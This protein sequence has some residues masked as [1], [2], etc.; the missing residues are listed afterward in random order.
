M[1]LLPLRLF[2]TLLFIAFSILGFSAYAQSNTAQEKTFTTITYKTSQKGEP[3]KLDIFQPDKIIAGQ[4]NPVVMIIHGGGWVEGDRTLK[5]IYYMQ[6]LQQSLTERG[7]AV[8]SIDYTLVGKDVHFMAPIIDCKDAIRWVKANADKYHFDADHIGLWGGSAGGHLA[9]LA[10]YTDDTIWPGDKQMADYP[11]NVKCVSD[12][13]GP[14]DMNAL[15][16]TEAGKFSLLLFKIVAGKLLPLR[17]RLIYA[18][19][20]RSITNQKEDAVRIAKEISPLEYVSPSSVPTLIMHGTK[21]KVVPLKQS[22][23]LHQLLNHHQ[24]INELHIVKKGD[25]GFNNIS[26]EET[27]ALVEKTADFFDVYLKKGN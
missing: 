1:K 19:T 26:H 8:V 12:N 14:T 17:E 9:L 22:K 23:K 6:K 21:D 13:F 7:Y 10:A 5:T 27:D 15:L 20:G 16:K 3:I 4:K 11:A 2:T 18:V 24:V 25:H